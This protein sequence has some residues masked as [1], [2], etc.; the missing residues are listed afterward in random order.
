MEKKTH[1][2]YALKLPNEVKAQFRIRGQQLKTQFPFQRWVHHEDTH[3]TLAFLGYAESTQ[4]ESSIH[5]VKEALRPHQSFSLTIN[6][7][8]VFGK[9]DAP[10]IFWAGTERE[11][12]LNE[13]RNSVFSACQ[14]AGFQLESRPFHPHITLARKWAGQQPFSQRLLQENHP[15]ANQA[16]HFLANEVVLYETHL[17]RQPKYEVKESFLLR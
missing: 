6:Q 13:L 7:L 12:L 10:R 3:I 15:Y 17:D 1:Y 8:G 2:F 9:S 16:L 14:K 5:F 11:N 4:L